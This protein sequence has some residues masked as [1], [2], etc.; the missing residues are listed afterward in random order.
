LSIRFTGDLQ[1]LALPPVKRG[2]V[3]L[4]TPSLNVNVVLMEPGE[5]AI[6]NGPLST[7]RLVDT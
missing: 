7:L 3:Q 2:L 4:R 1:N 6:E 5:F